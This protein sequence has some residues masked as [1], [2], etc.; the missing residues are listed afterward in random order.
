MNQPQSIKS[1]ANKVLSKR[2]PSN[3]VSNFHRTPEFE[4]GSNREHIVEPKFEPLYASGTEKV[5]SRQAEA[6]IRAWLAH[7]RETDP[8][9]IDDVLTR[10]AGDPDCLAYF[11][12]RATETPPSQRVVAHTVGDAQVVVEREL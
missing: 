11:M 4:G 10:C 8:V 7:I 9:L 3:S 6:T 5:V 1:L 2:Q 12:T